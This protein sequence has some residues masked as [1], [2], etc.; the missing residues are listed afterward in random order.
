M[1]QNSA[2]FQAF[3]TSLVTTHRVSGTNVFRA[4]HLHIKGFC[5]QN[6]IQEYHDNKRKAMCCK[7]QLL[8]GES[9]ASLGS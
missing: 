4:K 3:P 2:Y 7:A 1:S 6:I 5:S 8:G 9:P